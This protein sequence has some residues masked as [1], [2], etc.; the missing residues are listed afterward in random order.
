MQ[1]NNITLKRG[2]IIRSKYNN[3]VLYKITK[4]NKESI[5]VVSY[6]EDNI[7]QGIN[8]HGQD[9]EDFEIAK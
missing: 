4:I 1:I 2:M 6:S 9:P 5:D 7:L 3:I 8:Y